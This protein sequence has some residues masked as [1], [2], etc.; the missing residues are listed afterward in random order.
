MVKHIYT[1]KRP[2][3]IV[4][5]VTEDEQAMIEANMQ[6]AGI[7]NREA[8]LRKMAI[9]GHVLVLDLSDVSKMVSL[10]R[11][12]TSNL[13]QV[14]RR[15]NETRSI[16]ESDIRDLQAAYDRLWEQASGILSGLARL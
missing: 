2:V 9:D 5:Y 12:A 1:R 11:N 8:Y 7:Q 10:L 14:A 13:N 6:R 15:A 3:R 4:F 16:Y